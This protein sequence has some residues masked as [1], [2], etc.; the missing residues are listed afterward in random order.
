MILKYL[1]DQ[2][3]IGLNCC[4]SGLDSDKKI[5]QFG[6]LWCLRS[7]VSEWT[8]AGVS[9]NFENRSGAGVAFLK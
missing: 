1:A 4:R 3:W 6:N 5:S 2:D 8:P 9:T 7:G